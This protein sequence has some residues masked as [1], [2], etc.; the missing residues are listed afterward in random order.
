MARSQCPICATPLETRVVAPC[1]D[2]GHLPRELDDLDENAHT[3]DEVEL[4]GSQAV[5]CDFCQVDFDSYDPAYFGRPRGASVGTGMQFIRE[6]RD[7][8]PGVDAYCPTCQRRLAFL[9][10]LAEA[11]AAALSQQR[12]PDHGPAELSLDDPKCQPT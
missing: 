11:R 9:R 12:P 1:Y 10:F 2:C 7:P 5:L 8:R 3:Y 4:L 6:I